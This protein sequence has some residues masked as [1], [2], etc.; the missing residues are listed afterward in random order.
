MYIISISMI[1]K[2][3]KM[4][5]KTIKE[6]RTEAGL[7]QKQ[8]SNLTT[9]PLQTIQHWEIGFRNPAKYVVHLIYKE[10]LH[11]GYIKNSNGITKGE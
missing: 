11:E 3:A 2:R 6:L 7:T 10:L 4:M 5:E 8:L 9:V 1:Y